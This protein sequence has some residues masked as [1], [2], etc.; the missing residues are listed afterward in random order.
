MGNS[1]SVEGKNGLDAKSPRNTNPSKQNSLAQLSTAKNAA[2]KLKS[3]T[4]DLTLRGREEKK[5]YQFAAFSPAIAHWELANNQDASLGKTVKPYCWSF[6]TALLFVDISGF[7]NLS[8]RLEVDALQKHINL[9]FTSLIDVIV[10]HGGDV[11][12]FAGDAIICSWSL[13][14]MFT[15]EPTVLRLAALAACRCALDLN[16]RCAIYHIPEVDATLKIHSGIGVGGVHAFR[17]GSAS[18]WEFFVA[19]DAVFQYATAESVANA[20]DAV[21]SPE[22]WEYTKSELEGTILENNCVLLTNSEEEQLSSPKLHL[23]SLPSDLVNSELKKALCAHDQLMRQRTG[24][25]G[26]GGGGNR[27]RA[28]TSGVAMMGAANRMGSMRNND[29]QSERSSIMSNDGQVLHGGHLAPLK[30]YTHKVAR[31]AVEQDV[32]RDIAEQRSVVV[33]FALIEGIDQALLDGIDGLDRVQA[34]MEVSLKAI[35]AHGG[36]LRQF[37]RDDKGAVV[38]WS[39]GLTQQAYLDSPERSLRTALD[40]IAALKGLGL[41]PKVGVTSGTAYCGLVGASYRC[42]YALMG[43]AV[44]LAARLMCMCASNNVELLC[45]DELHDKF[46]SSES[47]AFEFNSFEPMKV[48]GYTNLVSFYHPILKEVKK[49]DSKRDS[50]GTGISGF[51]KRK[52]HTSSTLVPTH[53]TGRAASVDSAHN[54]HVNFLNADGGDGDSH[55][56]SSSSRH[57][58]PE[59]ENRSPP[60]MVRQLLGFKPAAR[61]SAGGNLQTSSHRKSESSIRSSKSSNHDGRYSPNTSLHRSSAATALVSDHQ[62][63][64]SSSSGGGGN[65]NNHSINKS[66]IRSSKPNNHGGGSPNRGEGLRQTV[67]SKLDQLSLSHQMIL[68]TASAIGVVFDRSV[69]INTYPGSAAEADQALST[70]LSNFVIRLEG[71]TQH[72]VRFAFRSAAT[73]SVI[74]DLMLQAQRKRLHQQI[75]AWYERVRVLRRREGLRSEED[76]VAPLALHYLL[77]GDDDRAKKLFVAA[78]RLSCM[79]GRYLEAVS[80]FDACLNLFTT[81]KG[82]EDDDIFCEVLVWLAQTI[83]RYAI[84][85][86]APSFIEDSVKNDGEHKSDDNTNSVSCAEKLLRRAFTVLNGRIMRRVV[87][88]FRDAKLSSALDR[89]KVNAKLISSSHEKRGTFHDYHHPMRRSSSHKTIT[90]NNSNS[91][92]RSNSLLSSTGGSSQDLYI[93]EHEIET[94]EMLQKRRL[95]L[96]RVKSQLAW[97]LAADPERCISE[98]EIIENNFSDAALT[99]LKAGNFLDA[100]DSMNG[101]GCYYHKRALLASPA[102]PAATIKVD[103]IAQQEERSK[104]ILQESMKNKSDSS[105]SSTTSSTSTS[106]SASVSLFQSASFGEKSLRSSVSAGTGT[107]NSSLNLDSKISETIVELDLDADPIEKKKNSNGKEDNED[108]ITPVQSLP[109]Q[110]SFLHKKGMKSESNQELDIAYSNDQKTFVREAMTEKDYWLYWS[111]RSYFSSLEMRDKLKVSPALAQ[112][113]TSIGRL[114]CDLGESVLGIEVF[115]SA[116]EQYFL[117]VGPH[118]PKAASSLEALAAA[119][120]RTKFPLMALGLRTQADSIRE[121]QLHVELKLSAEWG[122]DSTLNH[123]PR[124][125]TPS[126]RQS[127]Q[128]HGMLFNTN[129]EGGKG[130]RNSITNTS[131][132]MMPSPTSSNATDLKEELLPWETSGVTGPQGAWAQGFRPRGLNSTSSSSFN[133]NPMSNSDS[134]SSLVVASF[135]DLKTQSPLLVKK[136]KETEKKQEGVDSKE[137]NLDDEEEEDSNEKINDHSKAGAPKKTPPSSSKQKNELNHKKE[138]PKRLNSRSKGENVRLSTEWSSFSNAPPPLA[139]TS[140]LFNQNI[141]N[142]SPVPPSGGRHHKV[143]INSRRAS[144]G[145]NKSTIADSQSAN[146]VSNNFQS[147]APKLGSK[148]N[149]TRS[150]ASSK[151]SRRFSDAEVLSLYTQAIDDTERPWLNPTKPLLRLNT[152]PKARAGTPPKGRAGTPPKGRA[153]TPPK[154]PPPKVSSKMISTNGMVPPPVVT[155]LPD[156]PLP[157]SPVPSTTSTST[158]T[159]DKQQNP[160]PNELESSPIDFCLKV[161]QGHLKSLSGSSLRIQLELLYP[162]L[163][164]FIGPS[165]EKSGRLAN[166][167]A[168]IQAEVITAMTWALKLSDPNASSEKLGSLIRNKCLHMDEQSSEMIAHLEKSQNNTVVRKIGGGLFSSSSSAEQRVRTRTHSGSSARSGSESRPSGDHDLKVGTSL[169]I[170]E[171]DFNNQ[172][173]E[174]FLIEKRAARAL[175]GVLSMLALSSLGKVACLLGDVGLVP[176]CGGSATPLNPSQFATQV[177]HLVQQGF[178]TSFSSPTSSH[179]ATGVEGLDING[180]HAIDLPTMDRHLNN[181]MLMDRKISSMNKTSSSSTSSKFS[182]RS[183]RSLK[184]SSKD[185]HSH[186]SILLLN[187]FHLLKCLSCSVDIKSIIQGEAPA[188]ILLPLE[189]SLLRKQTTGSGSDSNNNNNSGSNN[190]DISGSGSS[191]KKDKKREATNRSPSSS[192]PRSGSQKDKAPSSSTSSNDFQSIFG[193]PQLIF[194]DILLAY[195]PTLA[196]GYSASSTCTSPFD[197]PVAMLQHVTSMVVSSLESLLP[198]ATLNTSVTSY[199]VYCKLITSACG[200]KKIPSFDLGGLAL[201]RIECMI[202]NSSIIENRKVWKVSKLFSGKNRSSIKRSSSTSNSAPNSPNKSMR[203]KLSLDVGGVDEA[204]ND[205]DDDEENGEDWIDHVHSLITMIVMDAISELDLNDKKNLIHEFNLTGCS[206]SLSNNGSGINESG[207]VGEWISDINAE[208]HDPEVPLQYSG[209]AEMIKVIMNGVLNH[210]KKEVVDL[211]KAAS[212]S[213]VSSPSKSNMLARESLLNVLAAGLEQICSISRSC[214]HEIVTHQR[215]NVRDGDKTSSSSGGAVYLTERVIST[216]QDASSSFSSNNTRNSTSST[217]SIQ[218]QKKSSQSSSLLKHNTENNASSQSV[219]DDWHLMS[220]PFIVNCY[221]IKRCCELHV[222]DPTPISPLQIDETMNLKNIERQNKIITLKSIFPSDINGTMDSLSPSSVADRIMFGLK[223]ARFSVSNAKPDGAYAIVTAFDKDVQPVEHLLPKP[224]AGTKP[225]DRVRAAIN[226]PPLSAGLQHHSHHHHSHP[227]W[228]SGNSLDGDGVSIASSRVSARRPSEI[229]KSEIA[230]ANAEYPPTPT[231]II[232]SPGRGQGSEMVMVLARALVDL[233]IVDLK[234]VIA[235]LAPT[236]DRAR[237]VRG[238]LD[239][240]GLDK[241]PVGVGMTP[242]IQQSGAKAKTAEFNNDVKAP[243]YDY[244]RREPD[245]K[246]GQALLLKIYEEA[247]DYSIALLCISALTD[248]AE[249]IKTHGPLFE[250]KTFRVVM[251]GG[252]DES[253]IPPKPHLEKDKDFLLPDASAQNNQYDW[254]ASVLVHQTCQEMKIQLVV[255]TRVAAYASAVPAFIYDE[256]ASIGHPVALRLRS[257]QEKSITGLWHRASLPPG[258]VDRRGLPDRCDRK[259]FAKSFCGGADLSSVT[260]DTPSIWS[261]VSAFNM[262]DPLAMLMVD[263]RTSQAFFE[264]ESKVVREIDQLIV[265]VEKIPVAHDPM[266][267]SN[268]EKGSSGIRDVKALRDFLM[269]AS[270]LGLLAAMPKAKFYR[271]DSFKTP[272][273]ET[274]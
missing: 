190:K 88:R 105:S 37:I 128:N 191:S 163:K 65:K 68:K 57:L 54:T 243:G 38:I 232:T 70:T 4:V 52:T 250:K 132:S 106:T 226:L 153:S 183:S 50:S 67:L 85:Y 172:N 118:H 43:P 271:S 29:S 124:N 162:E 141:H 35:E 64:K 220:N 19:G 84:P 197:E 239:T 56:L 87:G 198:M 258:H 75:A 213:V 208:S 176:G 15:N 248:V 44:N 120:S 10:A 166:K 147:P 116:V 245:E 210:S 103:Q 156:P 131:L 242:W 119:Y 237:L 222:T 159:T 216:P 189:N 149:S 270:R 218:S 212:L 160:S 144:G 173:H 211:N 17:V 238:T 42:E 92:H 233:G 196:E 18:H 217:T 26:S 99:Q 260:A 78:G 45:N 27:S 266:S 134:N 174:T 207:A 145:G 203:K 20:G 192:R 3:T 209:M 267:V 136:E 181:A 143:T 96:A 165:V 170:N 201:C 151:G 121:E 187:H 231:V 175:D 224:P 30:A 168:L 186:S 273:R 225:V 83:V 133:P 40:V 94:K 158:N 123:S 112:S 11:L 104:K 252:V 107:A 148:S 194:H 73:A 247:E 32:L 184:E 101:L 77:S 150:H 2:T 93:S 229:L 9:Y 253:S 236:E 89:W 62:S 129:Q 55:D 200:R 14:P 25:R 71:D 5:L 36:M 204:E 8:T 115:N 114:Q 23:K 230:D 152:P 91:L 48:K 167:A 13:S 24:N 140:T 74:Y 235:N 155:T 199:S 246:D 262:Y 127:T 7:T 221:C 177:L 205:N 53:A 261:Q 69:L 102:V 76:L 108:D 33:S 142:K 254:D 81:R 28:T 110:S 268:A 227:K 263:D 109:P 249:F 113:F 255:S 34:C 240:L 138:P 234:G 95:Q 80:H 122:I 154:L 22:T 49:Q 272:F 164:Y 179:Q 111:Q 180:I 265:G 264:P 63:G 178:L 182:S 214:R 66:G 60:R 79:Q 188:S 169:D 202:A 97:V 244:L 59:R 157:P 41:Q 51:I 12:R 146:G 126:K 46:M 137:Q 82:D 135:D 58:T 130:I 21:C 72:D 256:L 90:N 185:S 269:D 259:W 257:T 6:D 47:D 161:V 223:S 251:M 274:D 86:Q 139:D 195:A 100:S 16:K 1:C 31:S 219:V 39:F 61:K 215:S 206:S 228:S 98:G 125:M 171:I 117:T 193:I 241:V